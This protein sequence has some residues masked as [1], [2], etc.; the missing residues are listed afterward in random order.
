[1]QGLAVGEVQDVFLVLPRWVAGVNIQ[2][3]LSNEGRRV[4][5]MLRRRGLGGVLEPRDLCSVGRRQ[6]ERYYSRYFIP[7]QPPDVEIVPVSP[8]VGQERIVDE[9]TPGCHVLTASDPYACRFITELGVVPL[10]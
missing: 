7:G 9:C 5:D 1:L 4:P 8:T 10:S 3:H 6:L 2:G